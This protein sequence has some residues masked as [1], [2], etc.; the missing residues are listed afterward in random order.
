MEI[1]SAEMAL[2]GP[3]GNRYCCGQAIVLLAPTVP[4][5]NEEDTVRSECPV[6]AVR[7]LGMVACL[8]FAACAP[9]S[10][11]PGAGQAPPTA[12]YPPVVAAPQ[13][14]TATGPAL[15]GAAGSNANAEWDRW[16]AA[17]AREGR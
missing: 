7:W 10:P 15:G 6:R 13:D 9:A 1:S 3:R 17:A 16:V 5:V 11:A 14:A 12:A 4:S 8:V 2:D